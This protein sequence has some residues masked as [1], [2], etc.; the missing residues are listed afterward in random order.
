MKIKDI[1]ERFNVRKLNSTYVDFLVDQF[2][3]D[4]YQLSY[5]VSVT[6][7][8]IL[9][10]GNHRLAAAE[11]LGWDEIPSVIENPENIRIASHKRNTAATNAL[12][13]TF[14]DHAEE[15]WELL[16]EGKTQQ[17]VADEIGMEQGKN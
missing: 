5:P 12:P 1:K 10:D 17:A 14:V 13:E 2:K 15:I 9:W 8:G 16:A 3:T 4:G 11:K 6:Q 7:D